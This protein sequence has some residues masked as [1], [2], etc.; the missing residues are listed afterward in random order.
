MSEVLPVTNLDSELQAWLN[1]HEAQLIFI[2]IGPAKGS[3]TIDNF[4]TDEG[5][6]LPIGWSLG[7]IAVKVNNASYTL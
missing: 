2:A 5:M 4:M 3:V 7:V 6:R 1:R